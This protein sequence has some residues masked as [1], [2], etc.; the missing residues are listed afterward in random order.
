MA[1]PPRSLRHWHPATHDFTGQG[2]GIYDD[3]LLLVDAAHIHVGDHVL[4]SSPQGVACYRVRY[5]VYSP[6]YPAYW[7]VQI[8]AR[9]RAPVHRL[10]GPHHEGD[11]G[12]PQGAHR[13]SR[14]GP[15]L[16]AQDERPRM[17]LGAGTQGTAGT[18]RAAWWSTRPPRSGGG[19]TGRPW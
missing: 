11:V 19:V 8:E 9:E 16:G 10:S 13:L 18:D 7:R 4:V 2:V 3:A 1:T 5:V 6:G 12:A 15:L 14:S 17:P